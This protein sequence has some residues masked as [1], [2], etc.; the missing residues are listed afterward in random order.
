MQSLTENTFDIQA[1]NEIKFALSELSLFKHLRAAQITKKFGFAASS[2]F[3]LIFNLA[4][5]QTNWF[6]LKHNNIQSAGLPGK[7]TVYRFLNHTKF[8]WRRFFST[9]SAN[10]IAKVDALTDNRTKVLIVDESSYSRNRSKQVEL[11]SRF[12]DH[13]HSR[14]YKGFRMLTLG[15]SDGNTFMPCD[16]A[17]LGSN[18][19]SVCGINTNIDKRSNGYKRRAEALRKSIDIVPEMIDRALVG[20]V[21]AAYVLM[22]SWFMQAPL[23][24]SIRSRDLEVIC[25]VKDGKLLFSNKLGAMVKLSEL[26]YQADQVDQQEC[27]NTILKSVIT[28]LSDGTK[29]KMVFVRRRGRKREWLAIMS[30]DITLSEQEIVRLYGLRWDIETFFKFAKSLLRLQNEFAGRSYDM[31]VSHT[32]IVFTRYIVISW[33]NRKSHD[34]RTIGE[35]FHVM[36]SEIDCADWAEALAKLLSMI[37][38]FIGGLGKSIKSQL[39]CLLTNWFDSL[40]LYIK[41]LLPIPSCES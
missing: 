7:D 10:A 3:L 28:R 11:L 9:F 13:V 29:L 37:D 31:L 19:S 18:N 24:R 5:Q 38:E 23:I 30:T 16:F 8:S 36:C 32:T 40:P 14:Y 27:D 2:V 1:S 41:A 12:W 17:L 4:F 20:G 15:W 33:L 21:D 25:R 35:L 22:D 39:N 6:N 34:E 26:Y